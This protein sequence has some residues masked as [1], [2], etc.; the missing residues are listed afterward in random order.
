MRSDPLSNVYLSDFLYLFFNS[1]HKYNTQKL[2]L[3]IPSILYSFKNIL[4]PYK[5]WQTIITL[6]KLPSSS[7]FF[8][9]FLPFVN[10]HK[11]ILY[12]IYII[13]TFCVVLLFYLKICFY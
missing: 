10:E 1:H 8:F 5:R 3:K 12:L 2:P 7:S 4:F 13:L 9:F 6:Y 11:Q